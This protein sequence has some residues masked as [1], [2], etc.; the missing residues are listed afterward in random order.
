M[1]TA[2]GYGTTEKSMKDS[3]SWGPKMDMEFGSLPKA[4][5]TKENGS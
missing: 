5:H 1:E 3:G 4:T 2:N